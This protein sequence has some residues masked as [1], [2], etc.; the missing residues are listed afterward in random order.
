MRHYAIL[1]S[2]C[3]ISFEMCVFFQAAT[4]SEAERF[5]LKRCAS[6]A[7]EA[8]APAELHFRNVSVRVLCNDT[9]TA[10]SCDR[11]SIFLVGRA[12]GSVAV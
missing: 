1:L 8:N 9:S 6:S 12:A 5:D 3:T 7:T 10:G 4:S 11:G 2:V